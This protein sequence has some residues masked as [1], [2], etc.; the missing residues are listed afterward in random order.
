[1]LALVVALGL[2]AFSACSADTSSSTSP[3]SSVVPRDVPPCSEV[4]AEGKKITVGDFGMAC[5]DDAPEAEVKNQLLTPLPVR[6]TCEDKRKLYW[7]DLAY[8]YLN[9]TMTLTPRDERVRSPRTS[10]RTA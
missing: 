4:Y 8:G 2:P 7:N 1:M 10:S 5:L 6:I 9:D 3:S